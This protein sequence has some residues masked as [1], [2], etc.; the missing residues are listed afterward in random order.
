MPGHGAE[1]EHD[2]IGSA[3]FDTRDAQQADW[4]V[5]VGAARY[6]W[7]LLAPLANVKLTPAVNAIPLRSSGTAPV[8]RSS[9]NS[10][11]SPSTPSRSRTQRPWIASGEIFFS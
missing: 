9:R 1:M 11:C 6:S 3:A 7:R 10:N 8:F 2:F 4:V 5:R